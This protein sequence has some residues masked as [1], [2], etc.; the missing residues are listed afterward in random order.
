MR[1][2]VASTG[3]IDPSIARRSRSAIGENTMKKI[4][5]AF[6]IGAVTG[7]AAMPAPAPPFAPTGDGVVRSSSWSSRAP[8]E[9]QIAPLDETFPDAASALAANSRVDAAH[10]FEY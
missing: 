1:S 3:R 7:V 2:T 6:L 4:V 5:I 10:R 8:A 9:S